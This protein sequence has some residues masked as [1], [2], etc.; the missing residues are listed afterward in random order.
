MPDAETP[1]RSE[2]ARVFM[3]E[4]PDLV[5]PSEVVVDL[6]FEE[7]RRYLEANRSA[8]PPGAFAF[9]A[10]ALPYGPGNPNWNCLHDAWV[11]SLELLE[12][13]SGDRLQH[14][15]LRVEARLLSRDHDRRVYITYQDVVGYSLALPRPPGAPPDPGNPWSH[16]T[17]STTRFGWRCAAWWST[18]YG[19]RPGDAG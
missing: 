17:G 7:Y 9:A 12:D 14:R 2:V 11:E 15:R 18:R 3:V 5:D 6:R 8:F 19:S 4:I 16:G 10:A 13:A 1:V